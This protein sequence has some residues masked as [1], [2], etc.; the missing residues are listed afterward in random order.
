MNSL[1]LDLRVCV[2]NHMEHP[3]VL[4]VYISL[5]LGVLSSVGGPRFQRS[6]LLSVTLATLQ[7]AAAAA[8]APKPNIM[9][10]LADDLGYNELNFMNNTRGIM[11]PELDKLA[12]AG[13]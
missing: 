8:T 3:N 10:I 6:M 13:I 1:V 9:F 4:F 2:L 12:K 11:T 5:L 7:L